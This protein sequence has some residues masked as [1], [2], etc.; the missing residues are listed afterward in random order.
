MVHLFHPLFNGIVV[1]CSHSVRGDPIEIVWPRQLKLR[2]PV[3]QFHGSK[4]MKEDTTP[5]KKIWAKTMVFC[6]FSLKPISFFRQFCFQ[7]S[8]LIPGS[9]PGIIA[10]AGKSPLH[11]RWLPWLG[12]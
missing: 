10:M 11:A 8:G 3:V 4:R 2:L 12:T 7:I 6:G 9:L 1:T 5:P